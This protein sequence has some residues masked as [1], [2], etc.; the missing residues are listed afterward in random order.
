MTRFDPRGRANRALLVGVSE[1][2]HTAP[3]PQGVTG[4]L[5]AVRHNRKT[6]QDALNRSGVFGA[7]EVRVLAS[8]SEEDFRGQLRGAVRE[9][10]GLLLLY[11]A[12]HAVVNT[13][14][15]EL[16]LQM[17]TAQVVAGE[18]PGAVSFAQVL[19]QI[20]V[21]ES[22]AEKVLVILDC[23]YAGHAAG[24]WHRFADPEGNK[25]K[26][27]LL[28]SV[29]PN[30]C[31]LGGDADIATPFTRE[32]AEVL[33]EGGEVW[34]SELYPTLKQRMD[35][36]GYTAEEDDPQ[37][38]Q[39]LAP[40]WDPDADI[41]LA[42]RPVP[43][44]APKPTP[45]PTPAPV[46]VPEP[47]PAA[48]PVPVPVPD[49]LEAPTPGPPPRPRRSRPLGRAVNSVRA[50]ADRLGRTLLTFLLALL[51]TGAGGYGIFAL[52]G[53][54]ATCAPSLELRVLT[55]PDLE[56]AMQA[57][58]DAYFASDANT[59]DDG[60]RRGGVTVYSAGAA[61]VVTA[62]GERTDAWQQPREDDNPQRDI[63][64]QPDVW[65]P[66]TGADVG[67]V[68]AA[69]EDRVFARLEPDAEPFASSPVVLAV[70]RGLAPTLGKPTGRSLSELVD[71]LE[72]APGGAEV[73]R[74]DPGLTGAALLAT[75][76]LYGH[77]DDA[78]GAER[79]ITRP[80]RPEPSAV[81]L[82]CTLPDNGAVDDR[83]A[84]LVPE[85]L[86]RSGVGCHPATR[87]P[88]TAAYPDDVP[89]LEPTFVRVRW[90]HGDLDADA[91]D[92]EANRFRTWLTGAEGRAVL[93]EQGFRSASGDRALL[94]AGSAPDGLTGAVPPAE[95]ADPSDL[96]T[97]LERYGNAH[98]PGRVLFLLDS[99]GSMAGL[100]D[101]PSGGPGILKQT[102]S[103]LG[104][105]DE[106]GMWAVHGLT[107]RT[108]TELLPFGTHPR[109]DAEQALDTGKVRDAEADPPAALLDALTFMRERGADDERPQLIVYLTDGEDDTRLTGDRLKQ[110]VDR[111]GTAGMP[112][113][114]M[115][116]LNSGACDSGRPGTLIAEAGR[117]RCL[118]AG[119][120][121]VPALRDEVARIGT[122]EE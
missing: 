12:G 65:I 37:I 75:A 60:C 93:G 86:L 48:D 64:P 27:L 70:P 21:A 56:P 16:H 47:A 36:A 102:L 4:Q 119:D 99:S 77:G 108:H 8:P 116:T 71:A 19:G 59:T 90:D 98:G 10:E 29:Q 7:G 81:K 78:R 34:L 38:P 23:C 114:A 28:M 73:H 69:Q 31:I 107:G 118:D 2:D 32:L 11:F 76:G 68:A 88:R 82:L 84:A 1:Y 79:L 63:G 18:L 33:D 91:R 52:M 42:A 53:D 40:P 89:G 92:D 3:D 85:F 67:R 95:S 106:Y 57:A 66:A 43:S 87:V 113:V 83:G 13:S 45:A 94:D 58:A 24:V 61:A 122:G 9:A 115:V 5:P 103:G 46:P 110:V 55:D 120:D 22:R 112:P 49:P 72:G 80:E 74:P 35:E 111:A 25:E 54:S 97:A 96:D 15:G 51:A 100:W 101:G 39:A 105:E 104:G 20:C 6:L 17:R 26:V 109:E 30:R 14:G 41:L 62:L 117:G 121:L 44:P 50:V